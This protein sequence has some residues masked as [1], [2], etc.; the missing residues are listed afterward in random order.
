MGAICLE[1]K[2]AE[3]EVKG[4]AEGEQV[5]TALQKYFWVEFGSGVNADASPHP[6][7]LLMVLDMSLF[8]L[9]KRWVKSPWGS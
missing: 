5:C 6:G 7:K 1:K 4:V 2:V 9:K 8:S 3:M